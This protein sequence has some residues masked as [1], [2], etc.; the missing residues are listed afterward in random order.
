MSQ[1]A[2]DLLNK[3]FPKPD[4][5]HPSSTKP[6]L[7]ELLSRNATFVNLFESWMAESA[8]SLLEK[9]RLDLAKSVQPNMSLHFRRHS[10]TGAEGLLLDLPAFL[11]DTG[12]FLHEMLKNRILDSGYRLQM[13]DRQY[14][15]D[16]E[17]VKRTDR[18][19]LKPEPSEDGI[20]P[21]NQRWGNVLLELHVEGRI[22]R[23][24]KIQV[25][26]YTDRQFTAALP[27]DA[28]FT[29]LFEP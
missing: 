20:P 22:P 1:F 24:L 28:L 3:L 4:T 2:A 16:S 17:E 23:F 26:T 19:Y 6:F 10:F 27:V 11:P 12:E 29:L 9:L 5:R 25:N 14:F 15:S 18:F 7:T 13:A 21:F 8:P